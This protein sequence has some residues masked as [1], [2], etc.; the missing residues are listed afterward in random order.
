MINVYRKA[1]SGF[2]LVTGLLGLSACSTVDKLTSS[3]TEKP[4]ANY[5]NNKS[6]KNLE[7]PPDL[8]TPE[9]DNAFALPKGVVSAVSLQRGEYR[10]EVKSLADYSASDGPSTI[11]SI[12]GRRVLRVNSE[13][14]KSL[15]S[16]EKALTKMK[17]ATVSK[18]DKGDVI[19]AKYTGKDVLLSGAKPQSFLSHV[20][21]GGKRKRLLKFDGALERESIYVIFVK[22]ERGASI[23]RVTRADGEAL[24]NEAHAKIMELMNSAFSS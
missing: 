24:T 6:V 21:L 1:I 23:V 3:F 13:Y 11:V 10:N 2:L 18:S 12:S 16:T 9:F 8:T 14:S 4:T 5:Q 15:V 22:Q 7:V 19:T 20:V 17:F